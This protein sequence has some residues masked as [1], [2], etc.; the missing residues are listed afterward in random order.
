MSQTKIKHVAI[1]V[2][3]SREDKS[4]T[5]TAEGQ[6]EVLERIAK[7][8]N[9]TFEKFIESGD[10]SS[11]SLERPELQNLLRKVEN[12]QFDAVLCTEQSRLSLNTK[13]F[14]EIKDIFIETG[15]YFVTESKTITDFSNP[16]A[17]LYSEL[18]AVI[19]KNE[20]LRT[21][22]RLM[23]G[24]N[25]NV[26]KGKWQGQPPYGFK[27]NPTTKK[28]EVIEPEAAIIKKIFEMYSTEFN[29]EEIAFQLNAEGVP[30][31]RGGKWNQ[32][33]ITGMLK[34]EAYLGKIVYGKT[35]VTCN[36]TTEDVPPED[37]IVV[38][39]AH[40]KIIDQ[41]LW[42][43]A[44]QAL[45]R[46]RVIPKSARAGKRIFSG[47]IYCAKCQ[48]MFVFQEKH[49][50]L[51]M[52]KCVT[53]DI[54]SG[55][56]CQNRGI[57]MRVMNNLVFKKLQLDAQSIDAEIESLLA[58]QGEFIEQIRTN[59]EQ[60]Q[61]QLT[62]LTNRRKNIMEAR[63]DGDITKEEARPLIDDVDAKIK[64]ISTELKAL[65]N[66]SVDS[67]V[68]KKKQLKS[69]ILH[70]L[71]NRDGMDDLEKNRILR[72]FIKK[73]WFLREDDSPKEDYSTTYINIEYL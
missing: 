32:K 1:Y 44:Q 16:D 47:L 24:R 3:H 68:E 41:E 23:R 19:D 18:M 59:K 33:T 10:A 26:A 67:E 45:E 64:H 61:T 57:P 11:Q 30:T 38:E 65:E 70:F 62:K 46:R 63:F 13:H 22:K 34:Q 17:D 49:G 40:P 69:A 39:N 9:W 73:I 20:W 43:K 29:A 21:R 14:A 15:T 25:E 60:L 58:E 2:R 28:L 48:K 72:S 52:R 8:F 35:R 71:K 51:Y 27:K 12:L 56:E 7:E 5:K 6:L 36:K 66:T 31:S 4:G 53:R 55:H 54:E 37:W 42:Y 50:K